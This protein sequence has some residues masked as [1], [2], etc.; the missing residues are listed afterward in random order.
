[1]NPET[2]FSC[3]PADLKEKR[4]CELITIME[5]NPSTGPNPFST[6]KIIV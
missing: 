4:L 3:T 1:M 2:I 6:Y 5:K